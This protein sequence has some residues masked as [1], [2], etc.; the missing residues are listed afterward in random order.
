MLR[1]SS[2]YNINKRAF[3][4]THSERNCGV[5]NFFSNSIPLS[6]KI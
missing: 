4:E 1:A 6:I 3:K 2:V 5:R